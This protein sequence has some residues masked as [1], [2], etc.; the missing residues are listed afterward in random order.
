[1][2]SLVNS[3]H[4]MSCDMCV[5]ALELLMAKAQPPAEEDYLVVYQKCK[6]AI[7]L[8]S[9]LGHHLSSPS[10]SELLQGLFGLLGELIRS[11]NGYA[12]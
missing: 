9:K 12:Y 1:M 10:A 7:N 3:Y 4:V 2:H 8:V 11:N 5:A 6:Y